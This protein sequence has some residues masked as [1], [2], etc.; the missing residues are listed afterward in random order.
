MYNIV[1]SRYI[2]Y[3]NVDVLYISITAQ[4]RYVETKVY[5]AEEMTEDGD[6]NNVLL[7]L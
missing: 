5:W 7:G 2:T 1:T 3:K 6:Y 4:R